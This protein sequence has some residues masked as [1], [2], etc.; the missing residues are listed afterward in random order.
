MEY[1]LPNPVVGPNVQRALENIAQQLDRQGSPNIAANLRKYLQKRNEF[2][3]KHDN[4]YAKISD[5]GIE[6]DDIASLRD[7]DIGF[8]SKFNGLMLKIGHELEHPVAHAMFCKTYNMPTNV[9]T[10]PL[11]F[12]NRNDTD[13]LWMRNM[14]AVVDTG[15]STTVF[16]E[17]VIGWIR[18]SGYNYGTVPVTLDVVGGIANVQGAA[19]D[20]DICG[21]PFTGIR[22]NFAS[23]NGR[24]ALIGTDLLNSGK[25]DLDSGVRLSFTRH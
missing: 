21:V 13:R 22:V 16:D 18:G 14:E 5:Q 17:S 23:L 4:K 3:D 10:M 11:S 12:G 6:V 2:I 24:V 20:L 1:K 15:C 19:I 25:L 8:N 9:Y 7:S